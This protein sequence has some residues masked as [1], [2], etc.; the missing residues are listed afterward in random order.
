MFGT[1]DQNHSGFIDYSEFIASS[2]DRTR[3]RT[4][5]LVEKAFSMID[6]DGN[7]SLSRE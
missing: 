6:R 4:D 7:G 2:M 3:L 5:N 1:I